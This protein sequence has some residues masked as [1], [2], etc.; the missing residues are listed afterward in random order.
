VSEAEAHGVAP[1]TYRPT[2][3]SEH[4]RYGAFGFWLQRGPDPEIVDALME[5][6]IADPDP[7]MASVAMNDILA[8]HRP[9]AAMLELAISAVRQSGRYSISADTLAEYLRDIRA[10]DGS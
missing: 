10:A 2:G 1:S 4:Y 5:A 7:R 6:A 8:A 3:G 9:S